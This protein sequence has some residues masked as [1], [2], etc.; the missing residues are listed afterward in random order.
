VAAGIFQWQWRGRPIKAAY[1]TLGTGRAVLLLPAFSTVSSREEMR[2]LAE[3]LAVRG[4]S[5]M[6]VD[7]P[8]FG[9][10]MR[11]RLGYE[12]RFYHRFLLILRP[13][14]FQREQ[15][16]SQRGMLPAMR[17]RWRVIGRACGRTPCC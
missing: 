13:W 1:E 8:G 11:G 15:R 9:D 3:Y 4:C 17:S 2:P 6:L 10:S 16:S 12:P 5:C 14:S 7:W